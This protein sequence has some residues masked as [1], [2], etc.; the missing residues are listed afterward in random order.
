LRGLHLTG[1]LYDCACERELLA[2]MDALRM[3]CLRFCHD[4][5]F[6]VVGD[7]FHQFESGGGGVTGTVL[8]AES[9][10]AIHTWPETGSVTL[11]VYVCDYSQDNSLKAESLYECAL[12][13]LKPAENLTNRLPRGKV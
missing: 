6:E 7:A 11:D 12:N 1:D 8:L 9:H 3:H 2:D 10:L 13:L 5:G 4:A